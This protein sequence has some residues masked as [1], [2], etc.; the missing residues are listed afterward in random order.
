MPK[1]NP[2]P[3]TFIGIDLAWSD[4]NPSG[5]AVIFEDRL[6]AY[7]GN[8][9]GDDEILGF[10][11]THLD[12]KGPAII[13]VDAPLRVPNDHGSRPCDRDLSRVWRGY[14]A[15]ALPVNRHILGRTAGD[16]SAVVRGERLV[17][18]L[19]QRFRF[20]EVAVIPKRTQDRFVC[21]VFPHPA[22][23]SFFG[24]DKSLKYKARRGRDYESRWA[25]LERYQALLRTLRQA[26]P[27]L[28]RTKALLTRTDVRSLR[29]AAL[30]EHEDILDAV[31]C[32]YIGAY[33][34]R[35]GPRRATTYGSL[36]EGSILV[37]ITPEMKGRLKVQAEKA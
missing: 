35:H 3:P 23:V 12:D 5:V 24:L 33:L 9:V 32:A 6:T 20:S 17:E 7:A 11:R 16:G 15:G 19:V 2:K 36:P 18:Q 4:R 37:P 29:G 14:E 1:K 21:E 10:V 27:V 28:K 30:K 22:L 31:T 25:E 8:L 13:T 34:W 26:D